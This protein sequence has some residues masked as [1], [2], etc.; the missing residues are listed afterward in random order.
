MKRPGSY[1]EI[2]TGPTLHRQANG[3]GSNLIKGLLAG[4][5]IDLIVLYL[6][7]IPVRVRQNAAN[8]G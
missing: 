3:L 7:V 2:V 1:I 4:L 5:L 6:M 8:R